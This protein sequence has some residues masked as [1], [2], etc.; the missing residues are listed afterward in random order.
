M[1][2]NLKPLAWLRKLVKL[3]APLVGTEA[4][5]FTPV[6]FP[7]FALILE[8]PRYK[9]EY[10]IAPEPP[11]NSVRKLLKDTAP[12]AAILIMEFQKQLCYL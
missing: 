3:I 6:L 4:A 12:D 11:T 2:V 7:A 8:P 5:R 10:E 1:Y 9:L